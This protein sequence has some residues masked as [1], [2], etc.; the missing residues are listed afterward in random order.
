MCFRKKDKPVRL[1]KQENQ[2]KETITLLKLM[3]QQPNFWIIIIFIIIFIGAIIFAFW[4]SMA[5]FVYNTGG[6]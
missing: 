3:S 6:I 2:F 4:E 1:E 5:F